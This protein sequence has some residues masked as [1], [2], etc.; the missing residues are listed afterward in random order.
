MGRAVPDHPLT[1]EPVR[2]RSHHLGVD[3]T[4]TPRFI[5]FCGDDY[6][7]A[8]GDLPTLLRLLDGCGVDVVIWDD[9]DTL[10]A[11]IVQGEV[12]TF[13]AGDQPKQ[14]T[15][16]PDQTPPT[17]GNGTN[18]I[19]P[20][21]VKRTKKPRRLLTFQGETMTVSEWARRVGMHPLTLFARLGAGWSVEEALTTPV[22]ERV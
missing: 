9:F 22:R 20:S 14:P 7:D 17:N 2:I 8:D 5:A 11:V 6:L 15:P 18:G 19:I 3:H 16:P 21:E 13:Q 10:A 12:T 4:A 1:R